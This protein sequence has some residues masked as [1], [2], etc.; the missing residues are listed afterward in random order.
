MHGLQQLPLHITGILGNRDIVNSYFLV[1]G[2]EALLV[3]TGRDAETDAGLILD[4]WR[5]LGEPRMKGIVLT[6]AHPDHMGAAALLRER[7]HVPV[8]LHPAERIILEKLGSPLE[9][10]IELH[11]GQEL[12]TPLG[13]ATVL[14]T[15]GH[16][17]GHVCLYFEGSGLLISGDQVLT[18]GTVYVGEPFGDMTR[19]LKSMQRLLELRF[20][21]LA[22]GHGPVI[23]NGWRHVLEMHEYRLRREGE[24]L[25]GLRTGPRSSFDI[26]RLLYSGRNV[27]DEVLAFGSRQ[28]ECHLLHL[29]SKGV[30][31]RDEADASRWT[32]KN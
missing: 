6:H 14:H 26:A 17:P 2:G 28:T 20:D 22:P 21:Q 27:P 15:P 16:S 5:E 11:D 12:D 29:E 3:D 8:A 24:I 9:V 13:S 1:A 31:V 30:V 32:L 10:D 4:K 25:M 7:W 18:N 19:Y 23:S